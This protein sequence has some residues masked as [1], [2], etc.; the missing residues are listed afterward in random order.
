MVSM[1]TVVI[2]LSEFIH[3]KGES[4]YNHN[5]Y[6]HRLHGYTILQKCDEEFDTVH[7]YL[8]NEVG[9]GSVFLFSCDD[10]LNNVYE[11]DLGFFWS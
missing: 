1:S 7:F 9:N 5:Y 11:G 6:K 8:I 4:V 3:L 2:D 10:R